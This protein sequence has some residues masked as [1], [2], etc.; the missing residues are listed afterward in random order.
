MNAD[1]RPAS[2]TGFAP[3]GAAAAMAA[4]S[5]LA[6]AGPADV[7]LGRRTY[8]V[9]HS[10]NNT[11]GG[12]TRRPCPYDIENRLGIVRAAIIRRFGP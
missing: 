1:S 5:M 3:R 12:T 2:R 4:L 8:Y 10:A 7:D 11:C 6:G 9:N